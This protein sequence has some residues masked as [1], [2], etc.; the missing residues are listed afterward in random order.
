M[1]FVLETNRHLLM[2]K[3]WIQNGERYLT[4]SKNEVK[5]FKKLRKL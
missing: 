4:I 2:N 3:L 1:N 5:F